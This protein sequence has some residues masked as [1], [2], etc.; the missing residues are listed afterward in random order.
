[1]SAASLVLGKA[2]LA[3]FDWD[4]AGRLVVPRQVLAVVML[5]PWPGLL[6]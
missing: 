5:M 6:E 1:V 4:R 3:A 2:V